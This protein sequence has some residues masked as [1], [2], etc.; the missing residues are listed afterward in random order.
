MKK[1]KI[2]PVFT[3]LFARVH[4]IVVADKCAMQTSTSAA[5]WRTPSIR[6]SPPVTSRHGRGDHAVFMYTIICE[7]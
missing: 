3:P 6:C 5:L 1:I 4:P 7:L 2:I